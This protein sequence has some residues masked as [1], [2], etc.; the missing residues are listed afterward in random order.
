MPSALTYLNE[1][2]GYTVGVFPRE[3]DPGR[4]PARAGAGRGR[5]AE[6]RRDRGLAAR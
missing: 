4:Q 1:R 3:G 5:A 2:G 6:Q